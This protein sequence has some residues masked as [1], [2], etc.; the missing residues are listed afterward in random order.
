MLLDCGSPSFN[1]R[2]EKFKQES[3]NLRPKILDE[4][5]ILDEETLIKTHIRLNLKRKV[6]NRC[7]CM[8]TFD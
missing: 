6:L 2:E 5:K 1:Y 3:K 8:P 4:A 7:L